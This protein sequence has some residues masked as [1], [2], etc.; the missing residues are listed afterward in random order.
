MNLKDFLRE[1]KPK[2]FD[3]MSSEDRMY[4][5]Y[6]ALP[7][8]IQDYTKKGYKLQNEKEELFD[9]LMTKKFLKAIQKIVKKKMDVEPGLAMIISDFLEKRFHKIKEE[10]GDDAGDFIASYA[11]IVE[12]VLKPRVKDLL[13]ATKT[14]VTPNVK[15]FFQEFLCTVPEPGSV[16]SPRFVGI[17]VNRIANKMYRMSNQDRHEA[18]ETDPVVFTLPDTKTVRKLFAELF[19]KEILNYVAVALLLE[20]SERASRF[21]EEQMDTWNGLTA[22]ALDQLESNKKGEISAMFDFYD[23][24][25]EQIKEKGHGGERV[26]LSSLSADD[27]PKLVKVLT[28]RRKEASKTTTDDSVEDED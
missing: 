19:G 17:Y 28:K 5:I 3:E 7:A 9:R 16:S 10:Y 20:N 14:E 4:V 24:R 15:Y 6:D 22:F 25:R 21:T 23:K 12:K 18:T 1:T 13:K 27:Y 26:D 8:V 2:H 11:K